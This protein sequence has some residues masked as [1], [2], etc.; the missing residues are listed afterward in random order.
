[1]RTTHE[2]HLHGHADGH[3]ELQNG[4]STLR[5]AGKAKKPLK[6]YK[7]HISA[8]TMGKLFARSVLTTSFHLA[9]KKL[10]GE[11]RYPYKETIN[12]FLPLPCPIP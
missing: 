10:G 8:S 2:R 6:P 12:N 3:T 9:R 5:A 7:L 11:T 4:K 1:M